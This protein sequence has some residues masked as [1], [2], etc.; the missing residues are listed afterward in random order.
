MSLMMIH[1]TRPKS[2]LMAA[3]VLIVGILCKLSHHLLVGNI[4]KMLQNKQA[5]YQADWLGGGTTV[6]RTEEGSEGLLEE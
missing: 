2:S 1:L 6:V 5:C 3:E 4:A